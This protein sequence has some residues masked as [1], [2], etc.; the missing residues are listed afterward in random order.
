MKPLSSAPSWRAQAV[1]CFVLGLLSGANAQTVKPDAPQAHEPARA[2]PT[3][4]A[5]PEA[6][7]PAFDV[8]EFV[9]EGNTVLSD[10]A[11][12]K[13][14][15]PFLGE[16]KTFANVEAARIALEKAYQ[17]AGFLTVF[18]DLPEQEVSQ[19][20]V[21]LN[22]QEG[23]VERLAVTGSRYY[24]QG[25]IRSRVP[26]L[27]EGKVPNFNVVQAQLAEVNRTDDRRVQPVLRPGR[28][29]N[30][31]EVELKVTDQ[32]PV[33]ASLELNNNHAQFSK[34]WRLTA[35]ARYDN[36]FQRDHSMQL[37][38]ITNPQNPSQ[39]KALGLSYIVPEP[40]GDGWQATA[41]W[42]DSQIEAFSS[43]SILG[44]GA[45]FSLKRQWGLPSAG[46][47]SHVMTFGA[48]YKNMKESV[49]VG[50]DKV[51]T[52]IRYMPL[53]LGYNGSWVQEDAAVL[54]WT[55][56]VVFGVG[57]LFKHDVD[58]GFG[59]QDQFSCKRQGA[60][61]GFA[62]YRVDLRQ[63]QPVGRW[64]LGLR[65]GG[66]V[67]TQ[68]VIGVEQYALGGSDNIRGYLSSEVA[69]DHGVMG[70]VQI[71]TPNLSPSAGKADAVD[72][73]WRRLDEL[74]AY[75]FVDA[76]QI[77]VF[78]PSADQAGRQSLASIGVGVK[79]K[80]YKDWTLNSDLAHALR[81]ATTTRANDNRVHVRLS[82]DF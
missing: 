13:A 50:S 59:P 10:E 40:G 21:T 30:S 25:Y 27:A 15:T 53:T 20:V 33:H 43:V 68:A 63:S 19:G 2:L 74:T 5:A 81:A 46:A 1:A 9:V 34:P 47:L 26:E 28:T 77:R 12:E 29:P 32:A 76:G 42:S 49:L 31:A 54:S 56:N 72:S 62:Y 48:D 14:V 58:C 41:L 52:P 11:I 39:S 64:N 73:F 51:A 82:A 8:L 67:A 38:A 60:D 36:L 79:L 65:L 23:R 69:G 75:A 6:P 7:T 57:S 17:D 44:R 18:V 61:G 78:N 35:S 37:I 71:N 45:T 55:N 4:A 16:R 80:V 70:S 22:V 3:P 66:Q 24:S